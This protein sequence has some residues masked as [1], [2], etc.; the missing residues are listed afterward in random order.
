MATATAAPV[1]SAPGEPPAGTVLYG[2]RASKNGRLVVEL[3][4][5]EVGPSEVR[6]DALVLSVRADESASPTR[7]QYTLP[8]HD[9]A[10]RFVDDALLSLEYTG[11]SVEVV[12]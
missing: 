10:R 5:V 9:H 6:I 11:C 4:C 2:Y 7:Q 3:T 1:T 8:S 12:A